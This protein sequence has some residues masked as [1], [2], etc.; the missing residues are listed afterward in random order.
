M[1]AA[2]KMCENP[3]ETCAKEGLPLLL[4]RYAVMP[5]ETGAP[6][7]SGTLTSA[8]LDSIALGK[9]AHYGLRLL[10]SGYVYVYDQARDQWAEYF[11]TVDGILSKLPPRVLAKKEGPTPNPFAPIQS[12]SSDN[13]VS[14]V[15]DAQQVA[16]TEGLVLKSQAKPA[17]EFRC[18]RNGS[19]P[20]AGVITIRNPKHA[21][22]VWIAFSNVEWTHAVFQKHAKEAYRQQHMRCIDIVEGK[23]ASQPGTAPL[24]QIKDHLPEYR[25]EQTS[26]SKAFAKWCPHQ[27][28]GRQHAADGL[29]KAVQAAR[30][31]GGAALVALHDPVGLTMEIGALMEMR[32]SAYANHDK[33]FKPYFAANTIFSLEGSIKEQAKVEAMADAQAADTMDQAI[34]AA[35]AGGLS[36]ASLGIAQTPPRT[37]TQAQL[38]QIANDKWRTYTHD[39]T[40]KPRFDAA[41]SKAWLDD[42]NTNLAKLDAEHIL[43]LARAHVAWLKHDCMVKHMSCTF[44]ELDPA[45][46]VAYTATMAQALQGTA[47][48]QPSYDLYVRWLKAGTTTPD[49]LL[50]RALGLNRTQL[51]EKVKE[52]DGKPLD[53]RAFPSDMIVDFA[54]DALEK[55]PPGWQAALGQLLQNTGGAWLTYMG[56]FEQGKASGMAAAAVASMSGMQFTKVTVK[57]N[58]GKFIAH[59]MAQVSRLDPNLRVKPNQLGQAVSRQLKLLEIEG[60]PMR[61]TDKRSWL[62]VLDPGVLS[63]PSVKGLKGDALAQQIA[64]AIQTPD[65]LP[66]LQAKAFRN[67]VRSAGFD[68]L[69]NFCVGAVQLINFTKLVADVTGAMTHEQGEAKQ[70]MWAGAA[71]LLGTFGEATGAGLE[72]L[73]KVNLP[74]ARGITMSKVPEA[75]KFGGRLLG[76]LAGV[77]VAGLDLMQAAEAEAKGDFGLARAYFASAAF[78]AG[79]AWAFFKAATLGPVAWFA[80]G[81]VVLILLGVT[82]WIEKNKDN[83]IQE[84]LMR[85]HFGTKPPSE[86]YATQP[87]EAKELEAAFA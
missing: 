9:S 85:C 44:D 30:P 20:L 83:K 25:M 76:L 42:F 61:G 60:A 22:K 58:K 36:A 13:P 7:L 86:K 74:N 54:K 15:G 28:N 40:G 33:V 75:L 6:K 72:A 16:Y 43:P 69:G 53:A 71:T 2:P 38:Q 10:R 70:R 64:K 19:A 11:V 87:E 37:F 68:A 3:C 81:L 66:N 82:W 14:Q 12:T 29:I 26:A 31:Q 59:L 63:D 18:A 35:A 73:G 67:G 32:K 56:A 1:S 27:Y 39:R 48:K 51:L 49:N 41:G 50:M 17:T 78:G 47:D 46:N 65:K 57:G 79:L 21:N 34:F 80:V 52:T 23:V 5:S 84:W 55:M 8:R 62:V 4:T 45:S 77:F 24:A